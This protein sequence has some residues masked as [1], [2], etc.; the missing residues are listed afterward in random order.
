MGYVFMGFGQD[1]TGN[2][3]AH[4]FTAKQ[5]SNKKLGQYIKHKGTQYECNAV[6]L[7]NGKH[8][9][10]DFA[11]FGKQ[12]ENGLDDYILTM[13]MD[14]QDKCE[15]IFGD[16]DDNDDDDTKGRLGYSWF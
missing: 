3:T 10:D 14:D 13:G 11:D 8:E 16:D 4:L 15:E 2:V 5:K 6:L 12:M 9:F 7:L 1:T